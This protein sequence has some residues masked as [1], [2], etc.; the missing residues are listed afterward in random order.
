MR[1]GYEETVNINSYIQIEMKQKVL[2][3]NCEYMEI[4]IIYKNV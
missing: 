2:Y 1:W 4:Q 3:G